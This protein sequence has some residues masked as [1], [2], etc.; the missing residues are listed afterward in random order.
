[1]IIFVVLH[2]Q[3]INRTY[4]SILN[5]KKSST[6]CRAPRQGGSSTPGLLRW[7]QGSA[8]RKTFRV[9][10][11]HV[12]K[13]RVKIAKGGSKV[14]A[15]DAKFARLSINIT[16]RRTASPIL[17]VMLYKFEERGAII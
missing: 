17:V 2:R 5:K 7:L 13:A 1:M 3:N 4:A 8:R 6:K 16:R 11:Y 15:V 9:D 14:L 12:G 10:R